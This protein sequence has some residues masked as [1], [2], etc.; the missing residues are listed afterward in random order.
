MVSSHKLWL[1]SLLPFLAF[2]A[3]Y[4][5]LNLSGRVHGDYKMQADQWESPN[6]EPPKMMSFPL[7][8]F[9]PVGLRVKTPPL[10]AISPLGWS[11]MMQRHILCVLLS[12]SILGTSAAQS[13]PRFRF[14]KMKKGEGLVSLVV[15]TN[16]TDKE[17]S[18][19][20]N[21]IQS[22]VQNGKFAELG[23][24]QPT[25]KRYGKFIWS[26]YHFSLSRDKMRQ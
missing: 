11:V 7:S 3:D 1:S 22:N 8:C 15:P 12:A 25:D 18:S 23:I 10:G 6:S 20:L 4:P 26:R 24:T 9:R 2:R 21:F 5:R 17:L 19:L 14:F 13:R 16:T